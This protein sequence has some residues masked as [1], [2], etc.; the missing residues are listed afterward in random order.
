[1]KLLEITGEQEQYFKKQ[2]VQLKPK[3]KP[4]NFKNRSYVIQTKTKQCKKLFSIPKLKQQLTFETVLIP[5]IYGK[6]PKTRI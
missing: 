1:M 4:N 5:C 2:F 3:P 6:I